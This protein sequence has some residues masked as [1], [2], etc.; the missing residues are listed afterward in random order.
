MKIINIEDLDLNNAYF[1]FTARENL[2]SIESE[3][4]KAQVGD[5]SKMVQDKPRVCLSK[6][7][8]GILG[9]KNSF[10]HEFKKL[11]ICDIPEGY[12]KY[13]DIKD[14]SSTE[15]VDESKVYDALE[16]RFRDEIYLVVDAREGEDFVSEEIHGL[17]S[18]YDIKGKENHDID[19]C[20]ID[21]V[22]TS[23]GDTALDVVQYIYNR[24]LEKNPGKENLI[25][26]KNSDLSKMIDYVKQRDTKGVS[27]EPIVSDTISPSQIGESAAK[28]G[29]GIKEINSI[30]REMRRDLQQEI[31]KP[32]EFDD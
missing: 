19:A 18:A 28:V 9:I 8:K 12:R 4:L 11:R 1:H 15:I 17:G 27:T 25:K 16:K 29:T 20:K 21:K 10:I 24:I 13:F 22:E 31:E 26:S 5:A 30:T 3:G 7:G 6:G 32:K 23:R 14:F 2:S